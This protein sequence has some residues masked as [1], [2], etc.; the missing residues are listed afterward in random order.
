VV[1][2][3][4]TEVRAVVTWVTEVRTQGRALATFGRAFRTSVTHLG[5]G[6]RPSGPE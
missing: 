1:P 3:A 2:I 5:S 4:G 6:G